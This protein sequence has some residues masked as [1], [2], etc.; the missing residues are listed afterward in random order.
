MTTPSLCSWSTKSAMKPYVV[1]DRG[2]NVDDADEIC[3][4]HALEHMP[5]VAGYWHTVC[6][7]FSSCQGR[8]CH[9]CLKPDLFYVMINE[10]KNKINHHFSNAACNFDPQDD[11]GTRY[12]FFLLLQCCLPLLQ[13]AKILID[14]NNGTR[15]RGCLLWSNDAMWG[16]HNLQDTL[17]LTAQRY[18]PSPLL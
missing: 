10:T 6:S 11:R 7:L 2:K 13:R 15:Y 12:V 14:F 18:I 9:S 8:T 4:L 5:P 17:C 16:Q 1:K 3:Y